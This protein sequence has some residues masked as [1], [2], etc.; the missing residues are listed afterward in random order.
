MNRLLN[1]LGVTLQGD[2]VGYYGHEEGEEAMSY[3]KA[4]RIS[5][6]EIPVIDAA[7]APDDVAGE[8]YRAL[9][10]IGF[11]Y[12]RNHGISGA[13]I[14]DAGPGGRLRLLPAPRGGEGRGCHARRPPGLPRPRRFDHD[15]RQECGP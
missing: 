3:A 2:L 10:G 15:R 1:G 11:F 13:G 5:A 14:L 7:A 8:I 6:A 9:T 4:T 12:V